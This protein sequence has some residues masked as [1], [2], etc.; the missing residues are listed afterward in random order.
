[1]FESEFTD[2]FSCIQVDLNKFMNPFN[3]LLYQL[4]MRTLFPVNRLCCLEEEENIFVVL[5]R[6]LKL[7]SDPIISRSNIIIKDVI[8]TLK[9]DV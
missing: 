5:L 9:I 8:N 1:M 2:I 3:I 4:P 6:A 7:S